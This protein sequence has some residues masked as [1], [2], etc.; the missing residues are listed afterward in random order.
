MFFP[1]KTSLLP[2]AGRILFD[3]HPLPAW[4]IDV[5][6]HK[7]V[8]ANQAALRLYQYTV[9]EWEGTSFLNLFA[10][11]SRVLFFQLLAQTRET[12]QLPGYYQQYRKD[13]AA[14]WVELFASRITVRDKG[15]YQVTAVD[16]TERMTLQKNIEEE[17]HRY[18]TYIENSS[19]GI[20]CHEF[21]KPVPITLPA[22]AFLEYL[23]TDG[24]I[25]ECNRALAAM[26]GYTDPASMIGLLPNQLL[27]FDDPANR[28]YIISFVQNGFR[29]H[30]EESHEKDKDG[31]SRYFLNSSLGIIENGH[32]KRIWGTQIDITEQKKAE[33]NLQESEKRFKEIADLAPVMIWMSD[34]Q[35][36]IIYLNKKWLEF[37]GEDLPANGSSGWFQFVHPD[38]YRSAKQQYDRAFGERKQCVLVYRL[39]RQ[40]G[41]YRWVHDISIPRFVDGNSFMGYVGSVVDIEDQ[42]QKEEQLRYQAT[43]MDN[44][45]DII[46][47]SSL[48]CTIQFWN[49]TAEEFYG[50][51]AGQAVG[52]LVT[53]LV[54]LDYQDVQRDRAITQV[55]EKGVWK[56][57]VAYTNAEGQVKY[58]LNT[59][60]LVVND[61]GEKIGVLTVGRDISER[62]RA[63][64]KLQQSEAFY[65]ALIGNS[66]DAIVLMDAESRISFC[67]A[68]VSH[69]LGFDADEIVGQKGFEFVH[70]E[71]LDSAQ[72]SFRQEISQ[73]PETKFITIRLRHKNGQWIWCMV[74]GHNLLNQ[75]HVNSLVI[76]FHNDTLRKQALDALKESEKRF[77]NL[78]KALQVGVLLQDANGHILMG[79]DSILKIFD[80]PEEALLGKQ[81]WKIYTDIINEEGKLFQVSEMPFFRALETKRLIKDVV[82]GIW[83]PQKKERIWLL[84]NTDPVLDDAGQVQHVISS[85]TD[86]TERKKLEKKLL[87]D[88]INYQRQLTQ[89]TIDGQEAERREMGKELHDNIG[90]QLTTIKL[91]LD[92]VKNTANESNEELISLALK[93]VADV[94]NE[95]RAM[96]R[97]LLPHTLKDLG[98][99]DS[100][101]ELIDSFGRIQL[102]KIKFSF[103]DFEEGFL[104]ENQKLT[105]F[106][107]IQEQ[108]NN[109]AKHA[110]ARNIFITLQNTI[111][112]VILEIKDDGKGFDKKTVRKGL[113]FTNIRNRVELFDGQTEIFSAPGQGCRLRV[114]MPIALPQPVL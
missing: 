79:N 1:S 107:I 3:S 68:S 63:E 105:L 66:L 9:S 41:E 64:Q 100:V 17:R 14:L 7:I 114:V 77:R 47:S 65:R 29:L 67:S 87:S 25:S 61:K 99:I 20:F 93:G 96:S 83:L 84:L 51:P 32:L 38:D 48:D 103:E 85:F 11:E 55:F 98:L 53:E 97:S 111:Q 34:E 57:E 76:Y 18:K 82:M 75:P 95:V 45:S 92:M 27:D 104:P 31:R 102:L 94:I 59:V 54:Q 24:A 69:V 108:F 72:K 22:I 13:G 52:K 112:S 106:R 49:K 101:S 46:I 91:F 40:D 62:K 70:P 78:V 88:S 73:T 4:I 71:D 50:I 43:I 8:F 10:Q 19:V 2:D 30:N 81:V 35:N 58:L 60:S 80:V 90:Q 37:T 110:E 74:R 36:R 12:G 16:V 21:K 39:R 109:I 56:G 6:E 15:F 86:I 42:K 28:A 113:G 89:A 33:K 26:Y 23:K 44:V 5:R